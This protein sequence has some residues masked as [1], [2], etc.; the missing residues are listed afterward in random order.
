MAE[1]VARDPARWD[2]SQWGYMRWDVLTPRWEKMLLGLKTYIEVTRRVACWN[3]AP[4]TTTGIRTP[5]FDDQT[6]DML[7]AVTSS[8]IPGEMRRLGVALRQHALGISL[9]GVKMGDHIVTGVGSSLVEYGVAE[10]EEYTDPGVGGFAF[11][12]SQLHRLN[13]YMET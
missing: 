13:I 5:T 6:I 12:A 4:D 1:M 7:I 10:I 9:D 8:E 11:R 2:E 3:V